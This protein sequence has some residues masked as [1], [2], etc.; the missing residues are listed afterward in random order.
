MLFGGLGADNLIGGSSNLYTLVRPD[1]RPDGDDYLFGGAGTRVAA[2][3]LSDGIADADVLAGDNAT[4]GADRSVTLL[5]GA[6]ADEIH[7]EA[8]GDRIYGGAGNDR[9]FGDAG[10]DGDPRRRRPRLGLRR[11]RQRLA[12][13]ARTATT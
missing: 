5:D 10:A 6:G 2:N 13:S 8:D 4:I 9:L 1:Q 12:S 11:H 7:G 3:T